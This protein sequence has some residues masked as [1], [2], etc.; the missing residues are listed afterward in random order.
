M[1]S[2]CRQVSG[3][4]SSWGFSFA[5]DFL[6]TKIGLKDTCGVH[7]LH[8]MPG[9][10]GALV[11]VVA[12]TLAGEH[13]ATLAQLMALTCTVGLAM[14]G[15]A[16]SAFLVGMLGSEEVTKLKELVYEDAA[17]FAEVEEE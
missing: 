14:V 8:G 2:T 11:P 7:N 16:A 5:S 6:E 13:S 15:G 9:I 12:L 4:L 10:L 3:L 17:A 1:T